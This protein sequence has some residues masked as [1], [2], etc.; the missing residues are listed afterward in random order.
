[1]PW[2]YYRTEILKSKLGRAILNFLENDFKGEIKIFFFPWNEQYDISKDEFYTGSFGRVKHRETRRNNQIIS[3]ELVEGTISYFWLAENFDIRT[4]LE[5]LCHAYD[6]ASNFVN[7]LNM[8][9]NGKGKDYSQKPAEIS[10]KKRTR[11]IYQQIQ[12]FDEY[13]NSEQRAILAEYLKN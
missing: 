13:S 10:A 4:I 9:S 6:A 8:S 11:D 7:F 12:H 1:M 2:T 3:D 5:E